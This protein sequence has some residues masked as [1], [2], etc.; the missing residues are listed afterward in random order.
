MWSRNPSLFWGGVL[1]IVGILFLLA[2]LGYLNNLDWNFVWPILLIGL[3]VWLIAARIGPGGASA[4]VDSAE[5]RE[6]LE[7]AKLDVSVGAARLEVAAQPLEDQL[8]RVHIEHAG[9]PPEVRL[10]RASGTLRISQRSDWFMGARRLHVD[11][12]VTDAIPWEVAC[13]TGAIRGDFDFTSTA[14]TGFGCRTGASQVNLAL[15]APKGIVPVRIEG[16]ALRVSITRP[17]AAAVQ[18]QASGGAVQLR[19]DGSRQDGLG[20]RSWKSD[21][22]DAARDRY[23]VTVS[24]GALNVDLSAR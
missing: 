8:Y 1:V 14:L 2:N 7:R 24:G 5:P 4:N 17:A 11:A 20:T 18:V 22:F 9:T 19:A 15:G 16:G 10:D 13:S 6:N 23:D 21:G 12:R 3:G